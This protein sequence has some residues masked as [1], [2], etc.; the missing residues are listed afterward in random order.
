MPISGLTF[1]QAKKES[2]ATRQEKAKIERRIHSNS[3][4]VSLLQLKD[5]AAPEFPGA[6]PIA[7]IN[8]FAIRSLCM[9]VL[10]KIASVKENRM[11]K[12]TKRSAVSIGM[13]FVAAVLHKVDEEQKR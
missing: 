9:R 4:A 3:F 1:T 13:E 7:R 10:E 8:Y 12:R 11:L 6:F 2:K 5:Y